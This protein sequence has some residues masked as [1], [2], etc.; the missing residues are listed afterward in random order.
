MQEEKGMKRFAL[1]LLAFAMLFVMASAEEQ[2]IEEDFAAAASFD[3]EFFTEEGFFGDVFE[4]EQPELEDDVEDR[5][6][7]LFEAEE[8]Q[9]GDDTSLVG[10][11][12]WNIKKLTA[13]EGKKG[14]VTLTWELQK[15]GDVE[16]TLPDSSA[17]PSK[18]EMKAQKG[19]KIYIYQVDAITGIPSQVKKPVAITKNKM[20]VT[21][22]TAGTYTWFARL[23]KVDKDGNEFLGRASEPTKPLTITSLNKKAVTKAKAYYQNASE[24]P[25]EQKSAQPQPVITVSVDIFTKEAAD[26]YTFEVAQKSG[27]SGKAT[28][29]ASDIEKLKAELQG[30]GCIHVE[31]FDNPDVTWTG[32]A[33][34]LVANGKKIT[35]KVTAPEGKAKKANVTPKMIT[36]KTLPVIYSAVQVDATTV[37]VKWT[38]AADQSNVNPA[39]KYTISAGKAGSVTVD[40]KT[41]LQEDGSYE[42]KLTVK[43]NTNPKGKAKNIK[44]TVKSDAPKS[45][46]SKAYK[47]ALQTEGKG[48]ILDLKATMDEAGNLLLTWNGTVTVAYEV[49][50]TDG[51]HSAEI[52]KSGTLMIAPTE[53]PSSGP[54]AATYFAEFTADE[55]A[56]LHKGYSWS[57]TVKAVNGTHVVARSAIYMGRDPDTSDQPKTIIVDDK[58]TLAQAV[59]DAKDGD[60]IKF[61]VD[62]KLEEPVVVDK[63]VTVD[64]NGKK[65]SAPEEVFSV[66][67]KVALTGKGEITSRKVA[68]SVIDG[69]NLTIEDG[70]YDAQECAVLIYGKNTEVNVTGGTFN[71]KDNA[72]IMDNGTKGLSGNTINVSGGTFNCG[73]ETKDFS[74]CGIYAAN[75]N[76]WNITGGTFNVKNG[77]GIVARAG[78]VNVK[79]VVIKTTGTGEGKVG[80]CENKV[81]SAAIVFDSDAKYPGLTDK[82]I[83]TVKGGSFSSK[84]DAIQTLPAKTTSRVQLSGGSFSSDV[85]DFCAPGYSAKKS[86]DVWIVE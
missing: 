20:T 8:D 65:I 64:L 44:I 53:Q 28:F 85:N 54:K 12:K 55:L 69:G 86:G 80:D 35:I 49:Y 71:V 17:Q 32:A 50:V 79:G 2:F 18:A 22:K 10:W 68:I 76:T 1:L 72:A 29:K 74:A 14:K 38:D 46:K 84:V 5:S 27:N 56:Q 62:V 9:R 36:A 6:V 66:S 60:T 81:P 23:E 59:A 75:D 19:V 26:T 77:A 41:A 43:A 37:L 40:K 24:Q 31:L 63:D 70:T 4:A 57:F 30:T 25:S 67:G 16:P 34:K 13:A 47:L 21:V 33:P 51:A 58:E 15:G 52:I 48:A 11:Q 42:A 3:D 61:A 82:S 73:I 7:F 78:T 39:T 83:V 45:K